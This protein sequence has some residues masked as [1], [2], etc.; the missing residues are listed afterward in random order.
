MEILVG[1]CPAFVQDFE[2]ILGHYPLE[3]PPMAW[4]QAT[5]GGAG[6]C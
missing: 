5:N 4:T 6:I 3:M 2:P 1:H